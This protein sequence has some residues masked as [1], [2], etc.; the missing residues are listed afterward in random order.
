MTVVETYSDI[1]E[2]PFNF[3]YVLEAV[4][5]KLDS[6]RQLPTLVGHSMFTNVRFENR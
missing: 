1:Q 2:I 5:P 4:V 3:G 6:G